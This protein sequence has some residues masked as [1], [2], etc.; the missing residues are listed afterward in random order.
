M[1][2]GTGVRRLASPACDRVYLALRKALAEDR[3]KPGERLPSSRQLAQRF[4]CS[5]DTG[6][7]ALERLGEDGFAVKGEKRHEGWFVSNS[8]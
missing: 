5:Q 2:R 6:A 8:R 1:T 4:R 7:R 3:F